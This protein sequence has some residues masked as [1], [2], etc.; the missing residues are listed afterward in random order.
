MPLSAQTL[1]LALHELA[2]NAAKHGALSNIDEK[3]SISWEVS[4]GDDSSLHL[5]WKETG[6]RVA[7]DASKRTGYG[8]E[9]IKRALP[10]DLGA[11]TD[12]HFERDG[13]RCTIDVRRERLKFNGRR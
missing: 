3:L 9:L 10:F 4:A 6:A 12:L 5:I 7:P 13:L 2:T 11:K 1:G 8:T